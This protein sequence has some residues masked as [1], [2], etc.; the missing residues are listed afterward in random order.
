MNKILTIVLSS[1]L[2][3]PSLTHAC[4]KTGLLGFFLMAYEYSVYFLIAS[5]LFLISAIYFLVKKNIKHSV[6][7]FVCTFTLFVVIYFLYF[8]DRVFGCWI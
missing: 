7:M 6:I 2:L 3:I 1:V 8:I 4:E 5:F